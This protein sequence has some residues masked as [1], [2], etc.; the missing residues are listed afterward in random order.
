MHRT[1]KKDGIAL[2][3][4]VSADDEFEKDL[5]RNNPGPEPNSSI[6]PKTGKFQ[7]NFTEKELRNFYE[8][9]DILTLEK[10]TKKA[11]KIDREFTA[12]NWWLVLKKK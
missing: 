7:K 3:R 5:M 1:L 10:R 12:T 2:I 9:F 8:M 11:V 4:V 6:W